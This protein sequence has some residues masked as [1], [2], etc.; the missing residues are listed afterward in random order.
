MQPEALRRARSG[1]T[2]IELLVVIAIIAVLI[3]LLLPAV[4]KVREAANRMSCTN[5]LKQ[6]GVAL[7]AYHDVAQEFPVGGVATA[8]NNEEAW[9]WGTYVLPYLEQQALYTQLN[10]QKPNAVASGVTLNGLLVAGNGALIQTKLTGFLC[11]SDGRKIFVD[12][13]VNKNWNGGLAALPTS[14]FAAKSN[15]VA[16]CGTWDVNRADNNGV[17]HRGIQGNNLSDITDGT[18][19]T[20]LVG[21]RETRCGAGAWAGNRAGGATAQGNRG[22]DYTMGHTWPVLND[23]INTGNENCTDGFSSRHT[24]G[25]NFLFADGSV[26]F[27]SDTI[28]YNLGTGLTNNESVVSPLPADI[29]TY[30][31]LAAR[32]DTYVV[33]GY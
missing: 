26:H 4:Q 18:S 6:I 20:F 1:F 31:R 28:G 29:G 14:L 27:I 9:G 25:A 15:Y 21:E 33:A 17:M 11:P 8:T 24:G 32:N 22:N 13:P 23:S 7:H 10:P 12:S 5:N 30:Q 3:G 19:N 2:L 16:V